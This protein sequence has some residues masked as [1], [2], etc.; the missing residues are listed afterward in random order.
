[1]SPERRR[2]L[3]F[4]QTLPLHHPSVVVDTIA[5]LKEEVEHLR[6]LLVVARSVVDA[7]SGRARAEAFEALFAVVERLGRAGV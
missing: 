1:M 2:A 3:D 7:K 5:S 4:L 6:P